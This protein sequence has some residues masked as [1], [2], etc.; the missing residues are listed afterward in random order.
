MQ[1]FSGYSQEL[2]AF[3]NWTTGVSSK[4]E[5]DLVYIVQQTYM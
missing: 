1:S 3:E 4:D 5:Y 2:I